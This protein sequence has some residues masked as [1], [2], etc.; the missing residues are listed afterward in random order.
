MQFLPPI[1]DTSAVGLFLGLGFYKAAAVAA[2][3]QLVKDG[4]FLA[5]IYGVG[6]DMVSTLYRGEAVKNIPLIN[7][8]LSV[9]PLSQ[10]LTLVEYQRLMGLFVIGVIL[11]GIII[12]A[13]IVRLKI[14]RQIEHLLM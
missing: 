10:I 4:I 6:N 8:W 11:Y 14:R 5:Q 12:Q 3:L 13:I 7:S 1:L 2:G 9:D